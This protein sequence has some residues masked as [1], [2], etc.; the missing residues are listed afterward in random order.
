MHQSCSLKRRSQR[1]LLDAPPLRNGACSCVIVILPNAKNCSTVEIRLLY[2][3]AGNGSLNMV[4]Y[5]HSA[6]E[7]SQSTV[8]ED[9]LTDMLLAQIYI[10]KM[11]VIMFSFCAFP[12]RYEVDKIVKTTCSITQCNVDNVVEST[13]LQNPVHKN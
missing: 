12:P 4:K 11:K 9:Q 1:L 8:F 7:T 10:Y 6:S 13:H 3:Q 2:I 5:I